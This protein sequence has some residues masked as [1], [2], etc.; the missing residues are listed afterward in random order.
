MSR[1]ISLGRRSATIFGTAGILMFVMFLVGSSAVEPSSRPSGKETSGQAGSIADRVIDAD[2][3]APAGKLIFRDN[4]EYEVQRDEVNPQPAFL[5]IGKWSGIKAIN[6]GRNTAGGY[7]YTVDRIPGYSGAF[8]GHDSKRVLVIEGRPGS[9]QTQTDFWLRFG[10]AAGPPDQV[11]ADVW[12]QFW[13]YLNHYDD[14]RDKEDQLSGITHGKFLYPSVDGNYP[15]HPRWLFTIQ[16]S[17]VLL[18][19]DEDQ[20][21]TLTANSPQEFF[22][23]NQ[24]VM[25][26]TVLAKMTKLPDWD[27]FKLG[28][29]SGDDRVVANKW[30]LVK[31][32]FDTSRTS[33]RYEGWLQPLG[34]KTVKFAEFID[35][36][37]PNFTFKI[38]EDKIGGHKVVSMPTTLGD[39]VPGRTKNNKDCWIYLDDF[40]IA[41]S[42]EALPKYPGE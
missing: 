42:E 1:F 3:G 10:D 37:T 8:P 32:H 7:L 9:T 34:G 29:T 14:P 23:R 16:Q 28:N 22:F 18:L 36:V 24:F 17:T 39:F 11:P 27:C 21:R 31:L 15:T 4:F 35:G 26:D 6:A 19:K 33:G 5:T 41:D 20:P 13:I 38:P 12:F 30:Y 2:A 25:R 40:A